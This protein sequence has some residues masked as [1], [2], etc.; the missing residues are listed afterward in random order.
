MNGC[1]IGTACIKVSS[2]SVKRRSP[3]DCIDCEIV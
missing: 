2:M 3:S 1:P